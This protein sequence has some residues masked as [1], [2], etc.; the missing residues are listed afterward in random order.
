M[1]DIPGDYAQSLSILLPACFRAVADRLKT[2][3]D[4]PKFAFELKHDG[5]RSIAYLDGS[6]CLSFDRRDFRGEPLSTRKR[7]LK[8]AV[9]GCLM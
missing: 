8:A 6:D 4:H 5:F 7:I 1:A 9:T 3:F 2:A